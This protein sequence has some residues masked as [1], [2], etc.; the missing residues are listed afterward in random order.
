MK[1]K[2][3]LILGLFLNGCAVMPTKQD[4]SPSQNNTNI[5]P[6]AVNE[7]PIPQASLSKCIE[8][9]I[10]EVITGNEAVTIWYKASNAIGLSI[11]R[12]PLTY[13]IKIKFASK[14]FCY[15]Y[16]DVTQ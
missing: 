3:I 12:L 16:F 6:Y 2:L 9:I 1:I 5:N 7:Y 8:G 14:G 10:D 13:N 11:I 4:K 15:D